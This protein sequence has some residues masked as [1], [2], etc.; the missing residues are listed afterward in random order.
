MAEALRITA[1]TQ[2]RGRHPR[3]AWT[4]A[5]PQQIFIHC[6]YDE[7]KGTAKDAPLSQDK[8]LKAKRLNDKVAAADLVEAL[9]NDDIVDQIVDLLPD[10]DRPVKVVFPYPEFDPDIKSSNPMTITNAIPFAFAAHLAALLDADV[11][12]EIVEAARPGR[13]D[14][15]RFERFLWQPCFTGKVDT[16]CVYVLVD[17]TC[18]LG[19]TFAA[20]RSYIVANGGTVVA[21]TALSHQGGKS[22]PFGIADNTANMLVSRYSDEFS[23]FWTGE[24][25][26]GI[27]CLSELEGDF[28]A[29]WQGLGR[30]GAGT[31]LLQQLRDRLAEAKATGRGNDRS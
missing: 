1:A 17:D 30:K 21:A 13:T 26:H 12:V 8:Y 15:N 19:G 29:G 23:A 18:T 20:L 6:R 2:Q 3:V 25:G 27:E 7:L 22:V 5:D 16:D 31:E 24:V 10:D 28:L 14:L 11:E 9:I 4:A